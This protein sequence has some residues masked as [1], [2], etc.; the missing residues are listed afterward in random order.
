MQS[1]PISCHQNEKKKKK[2]KKKRKKE[3]KK[4][5]HSREIETVDFFSIETALDIV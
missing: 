4:E 3:R 1:D 2:K 5:V